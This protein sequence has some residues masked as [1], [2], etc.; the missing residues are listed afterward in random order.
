[1]I[2]AE[3]WRVLELLVAAKRLGARAIEINVDFIDIVNGI[4]NQKVIN[5]IG[6]SLMSKFRE[7]YEFDWDIEAQ[8]VFRE[9]NYLRMFL[10]KEVLSFLKINVS[11]I[12]VLPG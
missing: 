6:S 8:H 7:Y 3:L 9:D 5:P 1:M 12:L 4:R 11:L 2:V 10:L